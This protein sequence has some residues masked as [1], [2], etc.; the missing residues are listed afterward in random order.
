MYKTRETINN[1]NPTK[2]ST[3]SHMFA[4]TNTTTIFSLVH[5]EGSASRMRLQYNTI[6][7]NHTS[8]M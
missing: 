6:Q 4:H 7:Y 5:E 1:A 2:I 3:Q 8:H